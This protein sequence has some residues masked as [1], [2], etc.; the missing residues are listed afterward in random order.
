MRTI[1][2]LLLLFIW[3]A[4]AA[5]QGPSVPLEAGGLGADGAP[6]Q[7][8]IDFAEVR[9]G[10]GNA[11]VSRGRVYQGDRVEVQRRSDTGEWVE[12][13]ASGVRGWLKAKE[14]RILPKEAPREGDATD[15][16]RDR[17]ETNYTYDAQGRRRAANGRAMGSGEGTSRQMADDEDLSDFPE[18]G[19]TASN[20]SFGGLALSV[21]AGAA[22]IRRTFISNA[23]Q[24]SLLG[25]L[26]AKT[27]GF[28]AELGVEWTPMPYVAVR[29]S[30]RDARFAE[31]RVLALTLNDGQEIAIGVDAQQAGL[32]VAGQYPLLDGA[33]GAYVGGLFWRHAFQTTQPVPLYLTSTTIAAEAGAQAAW[34]FG[35]VDVRARGGI[36][37][38]LSFSQ[39]PADSGDPDG[40][41][42]RAAA[43]VAWQFAPQWAVLGQ[44]TFSRITT[45]FRGTSTHVDTTVDPP[46]GR[47]YTAAQQ[48][49]T[50]HGG[51]VGVRFSL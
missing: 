49:D 19:Q 37:Y 11:Y 44:W 21:T 13:T 5:A 1:G 45:D 9:A 50:I 33:F 2:A 10:P 47:S 4:A 23:G 17:R 43:E 15:A 6:G 34:R 40:F 20:L 14:V 22:Q 12:V 3:P 8:I 29:G 38:P 41:G 27:L 28:S 46:D 26:L 48:I 16:G 24:D 51:G 32:Q 25:D 35:P 42:Y 31:T 36:L 30:F 18:A 39:S 7:V